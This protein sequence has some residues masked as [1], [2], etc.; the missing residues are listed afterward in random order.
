MQLYFIRHG[1]ST[2]NVLNAQTSDYHQLRTTDP[3]L[4]ERGRRQADL[5]ATHLSI[6][7]T[8]LSPFDDYQNS[9]GFGLTHIYCSL[10]V[11]SIDTAMPTATALKL[12]LTTLPTIHEYG[13]IFEFEGTETR[14]GQAGLTRDQLL[15]RYPNL[16]LEHPVAANGWWDH[17]VESS[18]DLYQRAKE[19]I[20]LIKSR[21]AEDDRVAIVSH[22]GFYQAFMA[23]LL[24]LEIDPP[25]PAE[26]IPIYFPINNTAITRVSFRG[27]KIA[28]LYQNKTSHLSAELVSR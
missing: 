6:P 19:S 8:G 17:R 10:M 2:N 9:Y 4:T 11:R 7:Y 20:D 1:E 28:I 3:E 16:Q 15:R 25:Y 26:D 23:N 27:D 22:G 21:H 14:I 13:G 12:P 18:A 24:R 5:L